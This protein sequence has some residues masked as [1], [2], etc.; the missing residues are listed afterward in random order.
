MTTRGQDAQQNALAHHLD[1]GRRYQ[2]ASTTRYFAVVVV[3]GVL[4]MRR[5]NKNGADMR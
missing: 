3:G 1:R 5:R 2:S 4:A